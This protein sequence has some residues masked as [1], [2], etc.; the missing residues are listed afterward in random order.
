[1]QLVRSGPSTELDSR[2]VIRARS[3]S[4][5]RGDDPGFCCGTPELVDRACCGLYPRRVSSSVLPIDV[6]IF[7]QDIGRGIASCACRHELN[8][9][10]K[11][12]CPLHIHPLH[13]L[14]SDQPSNESCRTECKEID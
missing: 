14:S 11:L 6:Q 13:V 9:P 4:S 3:A 2:A 8:R 1:M 7:S 5:R 12:S 10:L